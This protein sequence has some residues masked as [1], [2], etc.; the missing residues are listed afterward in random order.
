MSIRK[1]VREIERMVSQQT[2]AFEI[3]RTRGGHIAIVIGSGPRRE[4]V[5]VSGTPSDH[6]SIL[7]A[8]SQVRQIVR[9]MAQIA[10]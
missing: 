6:R 9:S 8:K 7:N 5:V 4:R 2:D 3:E 1:H 10:A